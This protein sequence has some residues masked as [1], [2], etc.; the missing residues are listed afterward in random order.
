MDKDRL[1]SRTYL[2][3]FTKRRKNIM[4]Q[5]LVSLK[6]DIKADVLSIRY[7]TF[8]FTRGEKRLAG[9]SGAAGAFLMSAQSSFAAP[10]YNYSMFQNIATEFAKIYKDFVLIST[11]IA[12]VC[13][14]ICLI[15]IMLPGGDEKKGYANLRK[16]GICWLA[17]NALGAIFRF[18]TSLLSSSASDL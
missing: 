11:I 10:A 3:Y 12:A 4:N 9:L 18:G 13:A 16:I 1:K 5:K 15:S 8:R 14:A 6:E 7:G 2:F 17:L